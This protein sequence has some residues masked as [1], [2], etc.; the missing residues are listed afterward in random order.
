MKTLLGDVKNDFFL[1]TK[2]INV[3]PHHSSNN[4]NTVDASR[5]QI[6]IMGHSFIS[7]HSVLLCH[8][9]TYAHKHCNDMQRGQ[10]ETNTS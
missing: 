8:T 1:R 3:S 2:Q 9:H 5:W 4:R 6:Q 7:A 10:F